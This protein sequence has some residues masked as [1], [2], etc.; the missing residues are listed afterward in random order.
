M[1]RDVN[2]RRDKRQ[3]TRRSHEI[4]RQLCTWTLHFSDKGLEYGAMMCH[5]PGLQ[6]PN[7]SRQIAVPGIQ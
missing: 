1:P 6:W 7:E 3:A 4:R 2:K 5:I